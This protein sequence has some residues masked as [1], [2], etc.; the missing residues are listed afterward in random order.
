MH[1][2]TL[3][4]YLKEAYKSPNRQSYVESFEK[5]LDYLQIPNKTKLLSDFANGHIKNENEGAWI[6]IQT[7]Y[8]N[9]KKDFEI[10][11]NQIKKSMDDLIKS[12][13]I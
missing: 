8:D 6:L 9:K 2:N 13:V 1:S 5:I 7:A 4:S 10:E 12:M 11:L 3:I